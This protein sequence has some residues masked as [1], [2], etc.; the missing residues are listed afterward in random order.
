MGR[1]R[2]LALL[3]VLQACGA[4]RLR[5]LPDP[6]DQSDS[7]QQAIIRRLADVTVTAEV[8][9]WHHRPRRLAA[10]YLPFR[11]EIVNRSRGPVMFHFA[12]AHLLDDHT[13]VHRPLHPEEV[14][15]LLAGGSDLLAVIP[16]IGF[17]ATGPEPT[18]FG[19][20][21]GLQFNP[22]RDL[23]DI[24]RR[25]FPQEPI[26]PGGRAEGFVYFSKPARDARRLTLRVFLDGP[27]AHHELSFFY[28]IDQ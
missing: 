20:E 7:E 23:R 26:P 22:E 19:L 4:D 27:F 9:A 8:G 3:L 21:L 1:R 13:R 11:I 12:E 16:S 18:I 15:S 17:E 24:R 28:A 25:A 2:V 6:T 14:V 10:D 5:A